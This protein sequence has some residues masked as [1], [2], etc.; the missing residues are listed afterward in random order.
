M[1]Y[2]A[3]SIRH[4]FKPPAAII[5]PH[6]T[7]TPAGAVCVCKVNILK[8]EQKKRILTKQFLFSAPTLR[9]SPADKPQ[10]WRYGGLSPCPN[11][12]MARRRKK[13][14]CAHSPVFTNPACIFPIAV[15]I[16]VEHMVNSNHVLMQTQI[17]TQF[18]KKTLDEI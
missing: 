1:W 18:K 12:G 16:W 11:M 2:V 15:D 9:D 4:H 7:P 10:T 13:S 6:P 5:S 14:V 3:K 8:E 17:L